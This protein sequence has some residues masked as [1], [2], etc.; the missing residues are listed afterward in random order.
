MK[1]STYIRQT[2]LALLQQIKYSISSQKK[3]RNTLFSLDKTSSENSLQREI[4]LLQSIV[5]ARL[6]KQTV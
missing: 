2:Y 6:K 5:L 1:K 4:P 3:M